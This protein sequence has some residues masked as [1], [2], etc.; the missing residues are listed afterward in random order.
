MNAWQ[1]G[2]SSIAKTS[3]D[4]VLLQETRIDDKEA[5]LGAED[6]ARA[7]GWS[8]K[9]NKAVTTQEG[10]SSAGVGIMTKRHIG[11][12]SDANDLIA[13]RHRSR[14]CCTW[15]GT[16]RTGGLHVLSVYLWTREGM[17]S[18]NRELLEEITRLTKLL[19][20]SWVLGGDFNMRPELLQSW[21]KENRASIHCSAAPTCNASIYDYF[22][23][24]RSL[25]SAIIRVQTI[26]DVGGRP[27]VGVRLFFERQEKE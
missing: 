19:K 26:S 15:I 6:S 2:I 12:K 8:A 22:I 24:H 11:M 23:V 17:T 4:S 27:H 7:K 21:A 3:A 9:I 10:G 20:G 1:A 25:T 18:R 14:I 5:C 13:Q 16:G